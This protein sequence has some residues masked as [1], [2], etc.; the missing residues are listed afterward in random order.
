MK[1]KLLLPLIIEA[2]NPASFQA[3]LKEEMV[4]LHAGGYKISDVQTHITP[5]VVVDASFWKER[6]RQIHHYIAIILYW[7]EEENEKKTIDTLS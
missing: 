7:E 4:N 6:I 3:R 5:F 2:Y 1:K